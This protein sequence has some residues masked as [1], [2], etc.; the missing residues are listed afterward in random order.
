[1]AAAKSTAAADSGAGPAAGN[2][3]DEEYVDIDAI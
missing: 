2:E 1:V 3:S